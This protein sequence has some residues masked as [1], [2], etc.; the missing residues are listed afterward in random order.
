MSG[1]GLGESFD[2]EVILKT[3]LLATAIREVVHADLP[4]SDGV[5]LLLPTEADSDVDGENGSMHGGRNG[6]TDTWGQ[7][8]RSTHGGAPNGV[9]GVN[10]RTG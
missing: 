3:D 9:Q 10:P 5:P 4:D 8:A 2:N 6:P 1:H 7:L